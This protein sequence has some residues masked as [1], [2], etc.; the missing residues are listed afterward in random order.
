MTLSDPTA[1]QREL[2]DEFPGVYAGYNLN[3]QTGVLWDS[4]QLCA[5]EAADRLELFRVP[6]GAPDQHG[7]LKSIRDTNM[8]Q[9]GRLDAPEAFSVRRL[10]WTFSSFAAD[11]DV[12]GF[13]E[14]VVWTL[15]LGHKYVARNNI[16]SLQT[17]PNILAPIRTCEWC[18]SVYAG[19]ISC[20]GCGARQFS[21]QGLPDGPPAGRRFFLE[22]LMPVR[23]LNQIT[24]WVDLAAPGFRPAAALEL[25]CHLEGLHATGVQ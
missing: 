6:I 16:I 24:F 22:F 13:A 7:R 5:N 17:A 25:W 10:V 3:I 1:R 23:I 2:R 12:Y 11:Q 14:A 21:I 9:H 19:D 8:A 15:W 4:V 20:P 18:R